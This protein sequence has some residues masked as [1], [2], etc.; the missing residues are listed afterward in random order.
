MIA[1]PSLSLCLVAGTRPEFI[2]LS[3]W[4]ESLSAYF[5][6][7]VLIS[8]QHYDPDMQ[9][10]FLDE[11]GYAHF[12][13]VQQTVAQGLQQL[14]PHW[15]AVL[16]DT[17]TALE[18]ACIAQS[19]GI[20][21]IHLEAGCRSG[22]QEQIEE[23]NRKQIDAMAHILVAPDQAGYANLCREP[24]GGFAKSLLCEGMGY[25]PLLYHST[26]LNTALKVQSLQ[27]LQSLQSLQPL[28]PLIL[29]TLHRRET[30][31]DPVQLAA[32]VQA[33]ETLAARGQVIV[34]LHPHTKKRLQQ[35]GLSFVKVQ[36][37]PP[38]SYMGTLSMLQKSSLLITDSGGMQEEAAAMGVPLLIAREQTEWSRLLTMPTVKMAAPAQDHFVEHAVEL[39]QNDRVGQNKNSSLAGLQQ[40][41]GKMAQ[42][43][44]SQIYILAM[45][46]K[47]VFI[48]PTAIV[49][50]GAV[51]GAGTKIWH[52]AHIRSTAS[53]GA[54]CS[55]GKNVYVDAYVSIGSGVKIQ[56]NVSVYQGVSIQDDVFVG[57]S[58]VFTNDRFP[59]AFTP[60]NQ[61]K[62]HK[63][64]V[65]KGASLGA[66]CSILC[67]CTIGEYALVAM[68]SVIIQD[69]APYELWVGNPG[70]CKGL[71]TKE[72]LPQ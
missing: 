35:C 42:K 66:N 50:E 13:L 70:V 49:E 54:N 29:A 15:V 14:Q 3:P 47:E 45:N 24:L 4:L 71:V 21:V 38:Q 28:Q 32:W 23:Q 72:G 40:Q 58:V 12:P 41:Y 25:L 39:L 26:K 67:G 68:G 6:I 34:L 1:K 20:P 57:P 30:I 8:G 18:G 61:E 37:L 52:H 60:W 33:L 44:A 17:N 59:R 27:A 51:I 9:Q 62:V 43:V 55:I 64:V 36:V 46:Y 65:Q 11:L 53:I 10:T 31:Y 69:V 48:H 22:N 7:S 16:G 63:T 5:T 2:K 56:N 19:M